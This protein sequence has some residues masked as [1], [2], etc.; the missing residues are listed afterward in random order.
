MRL[1]QC[2]M[3]VFFRLKE[4]VGLFVPRTNSQFIQYLDSIQVKKLFYDFLIDHVIA[5][6]LIVIHDRQ[7]TAFSP[8]LH[9]TTFA[10]APLEIPQDLDCETE[11]KLGYLS[12]ETMETV[13]L[14][15]PFDLHFYDWL[16]WLDS[17]PFCLHLKSSESV[18]ITR[19]SN[20]SNCFLGKHA[21]HFIRQR[22]KF[23]KFLDLFW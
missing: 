22:W 12:G 19:D 8:N 2:Q 6:S 17:I 4:T 18:K 1:F 7:T 13:F 20:P 9:S 10:A 21:M 14:S 15:V 3:Y 16:T 5:I 23:L 11:K